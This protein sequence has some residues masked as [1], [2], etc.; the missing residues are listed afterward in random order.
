MANKNHEFIVYLKSLRPYVRSACENIS[1]K[2]ATPEEMDKLKLKL[3]VA[4]NNF[5]M[6]DAQDTDTNILRY[7]IAE[8]EFNK[9]FVANKLYELQLGA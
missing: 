1:P 3:E 2:K 8:I 6:G 5:M 9:L 7:T 4:E